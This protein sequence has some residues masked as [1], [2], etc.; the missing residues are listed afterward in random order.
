MKRICDGLE[1]GDSI[2]ISSGNLDNDVKP[3]IKDR[4]FTVATVAPPTVMKVEEE[5]KETEEETK[6]LKTPHKKKEK[7]KLR[8]QKKVQMVK[9]KMR[10]KIQI[11]KKVKIL[12]N[13]ML[14]IAGLGNPG[15][16]FTKTR[17]NIGFEILD[18]FTQ[19]INLEIFRKI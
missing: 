9:K 6:I 2:H 15:S 1:I 19:S 17:H 13:E 8:V 11:I 5:V 7:T 4:D 3:T 12:S 18:Y 16:S 14:L 10:T